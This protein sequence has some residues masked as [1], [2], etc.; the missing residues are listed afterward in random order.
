VLLADHRVH[1]ALSLCDTACL[2]VDGRIDVRATP[3]EF[4][5]HPEVRHRYLG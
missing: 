3:E 4:L 2:L 1:E 5:D